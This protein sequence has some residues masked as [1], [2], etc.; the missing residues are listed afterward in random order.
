[1]D[2]SLKELSDRLLDRFENTTKIFENTNKF[3]A[4]QGTTTANEYLAMLAEASFIHHR[5]QIYTEP[6]IKMVILRSPKEIR[7]LLYEISYKN[8]CWDNF[9]KR[10]GEI[11][12]L[13]NSNNKS[14]STEVEVIQLKPKITRQ[15]FKVHEA[16]MINEPKTT[17]F[18]ARHKPNIK[19][20]VKTSKP[21]KMKG[22]TK[23][24]KNFFEGKQKVS[25]FKAQGYTN[26][27]G[28][29]SVYEPEDVENVFNQNCQIGNRQT[30]CL[31]D[32]G[33]DISLIHISKLPKDEP[34]HKV[35]SERRIKSATGNYIK[36][37]GCVKKLQIKINNTN[38][39]LD[40]YVTNDKPV[41]TILGVKFI[42][43][44]PKVLT[45]I[46]Q[47]YNST[48]NIKQSRSIKINSITEEENILTKYHFLFKDEISDYSL[49]TT[50]THRIETGNALPFKHLNQ[51]IPVHW[52]TQI[53]DEIDKN[54][55][56]GI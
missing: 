38:Y 7:T 2:I 13:I 32:T 11:T 54:L 55:K 31:I 20:R 46:L 35:G 14:Q 42:L 34:I 37:I 51:R 23:T 28:I 48:K 19:L 40:A 45:N 52:E 6:L 49:C 15:C 4:R 27:K 44:N 36:I 50:A 17:T 10:A 1:S 25:N 24:T 47:H 16:K 33:A 22:D 26:E 43:Q 12:W 18:K 5:K 56:L 21:I 41:Y 30:K 29:Y 9:M 39:Y 8:T 3:L 53:K